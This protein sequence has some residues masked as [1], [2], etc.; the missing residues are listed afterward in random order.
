MT[1]QERLDSL[2]ERP[3]KVYLIY[4]QDICMGEITGR[5]EDHAIDKFR[6]LRGYFAAAPLWAEVKKPCSKS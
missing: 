3:E 2:T 6:R 1:I 4:E 5:N